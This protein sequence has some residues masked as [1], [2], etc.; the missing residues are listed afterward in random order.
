MYYSEPYRCLNDF[1]TF[2]YNVLATF[3][4]SKTWFILFRCQLWQVY[5]LEQIF[6]QLPV[7]I[8]ATFENIS[9]A[10]SKYSIQSSSALPSKETGQSISILWKFHDLPAP[11]LEVTN[12]LFNLALQIRGCWRRTCIY[13]NAD[14]SCQYVST[15]YW[16]ILASALVSCSIVAYRQKYYKISK[17]ASDRWLNY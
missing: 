13:Y 2:I 10:P 4:G 11:A 14:F 15:R 9:A 12:F 17:T 1:Y 3:S 8:S 7:S 6:C 5:E 16:T